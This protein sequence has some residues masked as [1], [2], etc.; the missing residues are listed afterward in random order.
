MIDVEQPPSEYH[1]GTPQKK[2]IFDDFLLITVLVTIVPY[3]L[4]LTMKVDGFINIKWIFINILLLVSLYALTM[5]VIKKV[6]VLFHE[7]APSQIEYFGLFALAFVT[8]KL[9]TAFVLCVS[10]KEFFPSFVFES[11]VCAF[12]LIACLC[13]WTALVYLYYP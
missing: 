2:M 5:L 12:L 3:E 6:R 10:A 13:G 8:C 7:Y 1:E 11:K 4:L 9:I